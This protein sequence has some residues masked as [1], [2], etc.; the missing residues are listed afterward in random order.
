[1]DEQTK[2]G[3]IS[4]ILSVM[5]IFLSWNKNLLLPAIIFGAIAIAFAYLSAYI[6]QIKENTIKINSLIKEREIDK[7]L[8][9]IE[10]KLKIWT[11]KV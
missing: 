5:A 8:L 7:R 1:M 4:I 10:N 3:L 11:E 2:Y 6:K 9:K